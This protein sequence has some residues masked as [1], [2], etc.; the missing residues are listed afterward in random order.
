MICAHGATQA[1]AVKARPA[2]RALVDERV[3]RDLHRRAALQ[4]IA[5]RAPK[6]P[7]PPVCVLVT[8]AGAGAGR[9][10]QSFCK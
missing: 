3:E 7:A 10:K 5:L 1:A 8:S 4:Q 6:M 9:H 2:A